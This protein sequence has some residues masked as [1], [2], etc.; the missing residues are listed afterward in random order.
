MLALQISSRDTINGMKLGW[1]FG[2]MLYEINALPFTF[3]GNRDMFMWRNLFIGAAVAL[4]L[5]VVALAAV[6]MR[7][8]K[9]QQRYEQL[10]LELGETGVGGMQPSDLAKV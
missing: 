5:V 9:S 7:Q 8:R 1:A 10:A 4:A 2:A 6:V 3:T